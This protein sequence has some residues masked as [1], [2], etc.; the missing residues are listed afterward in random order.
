MEAEINSRK[1]V[2]GLKLNSS[3]CMSIYTR[4][5]WISITNYSSAGG[6]WKDEL[7]E[8]SEST[9]GIYHFLETSLIKPVYSGNSTRCLM[10]TEC[11]KPNQTSY[12]VSDYNNIL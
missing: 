1:Y 2:P 7:L 4:H 6:W 8:T 9:L 5:R 12:Y 3:I 10:T 11:R